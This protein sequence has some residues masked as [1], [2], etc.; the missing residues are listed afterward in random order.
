MTPPHYVPPSSG[1]PPYPSYTATA[2]PTSSSNPID[3]SS[4]TPSTPTDNDRTYRPPVPLFPDQERRPTT[5][6]ATI[7]PIPHRPLSGRGRGQIAPPMSGYVSPSTPNTSG[8][9]GYAENRGRGEVA[10]YSMPS[11]SSRVQP[12]PGAYMNVL[13]RPLVGASRRHSFPR[14]LHRSTVH[15]PAL[16]APV[17]A[18]STSLD[19]S[20]P[21]PTVT[22]LTTPPHRPPLPADRSTAA[23]EGFQTDY[24]R[25]TSLDIR[26]PCLITPKEIGDGRPVGSTGASGNYPF[27]SILPPPTEAY[28]ILRQRGEPAGGWS[29]IPQEEG[30]DWYVSSRAQREAW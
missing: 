11:Q 22:A 4:Y 10:R 7:R 28:L 19:T 17:A 23:V 5:A 16:L 12:P 26:R 9:Y 13:E 21:G 1:A 15:I 6:P 2:H 24:I 18:T 29:P 30:S 20:G 25:P 14:H 3:P 27:V 8:V